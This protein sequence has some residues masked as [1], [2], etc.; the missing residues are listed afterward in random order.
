MRTSLEQAASLLKEGKVVAIPTETVYGLAAVASNP[1][2]VESLFQLK[3]RPRENPLI[4]HMH[5]ASSLE[6]YVE[7]I[8]QE[9]IALAEKFWPGPLTIVLPVR[10]GAVLSSVSAGL[11]TQAFRVPNHPLTRALIAQT[12]P[13]VAPSAN[14]SGNPSTVSPDQV[15]KDFGK[16]FPVLDGGRC[17]KGL[18]STILVWEED[19]FGLGRLGAI[20]AEE[21]L[22]ILGYVPQLSSPKEKPLCPG[23]LYR[24]YAPKAKLHFSQ[25][26]A[27]ASV[28]IGLKGRSYPSTA[29]LFYLGAEDNPEGVAYSLYTVLRTLDDEGI[30]EAWIDADLPKTG[31]WVTIKERLRKASND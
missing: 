30:Q 26:L 6:D 14:L 3:N 7:R 20:P 28:I 15:E 19:H 16:D 18:E 4:I 8:P 12:G 11:R 5:D 21:F 1:V 2:A 31:L 29:Q 23:Q 17:K 25:N 13:L 10:E 27:N 24:H 22:P 9:A